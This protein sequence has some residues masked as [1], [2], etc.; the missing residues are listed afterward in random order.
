MDF[1]EDAH[2]IGSR[3][4]LISLEPFLS[5]AQGKIGIPEAIIFC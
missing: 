1:P 3:R 4:I 2:T 5:H